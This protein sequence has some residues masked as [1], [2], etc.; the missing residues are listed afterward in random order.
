MSGLDVESEG[1]VRDAL[2]RVMA[3]KT[4]ILITHDLASATDADSIVIL[5]SGRVI[6]RGDHEELMARDRRYRQLYEMKTSS[7]DSVRAVKT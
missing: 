4:C 1:K 2:D 3:G 6:E 5:E 7:R